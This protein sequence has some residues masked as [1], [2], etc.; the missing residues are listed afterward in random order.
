M[1]IRNPHLPTEF[2]SRKVAHHLSLILV[3][4]FYID[5]NLKTSREFPNK[6]GL[7]LIQ[8][9]RSDSKTPLITL[10]HYG[11]LDRKWKL[12]SVSDLSHH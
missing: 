4:S 12:P 1:H 8:I 5:T 9:E 2:I 7:I 3:R 10:Y 6:S 11:V